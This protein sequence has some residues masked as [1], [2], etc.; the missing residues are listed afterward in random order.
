MNRNTDYNGIGPNKQ[1]KHTP[2][3]GIEDQSRT[4]KRS[5]SGPVSTEEPWTEHLHRQFALSIMEEGIEKAS[6]SVILDNLKLRVHHPSLSSEK[7][8]S[9]LQ[10]YRRNR[11]K[12]QSEFLQENDSWMQKAL[13]MGVSN[14]SVS[15]WTIVEMM[16]SK[17]PQLLGG[18]VPAFLSFAVMM[19]DAQPIIKMQLPTENSHEDFIGARIPY[20]VLTV[21]ERSSPLG[22][23]MMRVMALCTSMTQS[24]LEQRD[25]AKQEE[26]AGHDET[27]TSNQGEHEHARVAA[28]AAV[29][30][31]SSDSSLDN[32]STLEPID[33]QAADTH[34]IALSN[35]LS[36][37]RFPSFLLP[38]EVGDSLQQPHPDEG[39]LPATN[40]ADVDA[41]KPRAYS[42]DD[43]F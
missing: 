35:S 2:T 17:E 7:V 4:A 39:N 40:S 32:S 11:E 6:P 27:T 15:P 1:R 41:S 21:A 28:A 14:Q 18:H 22:A 10:K 8:K 16:G 34:Q 30:A 25:A 20:P 23:S 3:T 19:A 36:N 31:A 29:W 13:T 26:V 33:I 42:N 38:R 12:S 24:L 43:V 37:Y 5:R 9:H